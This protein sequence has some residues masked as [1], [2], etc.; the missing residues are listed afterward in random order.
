MI[1]THAH[2]GAQ[3]MTS[4]K[5]HRNL[6]ETENE[7]PAVIARARLRAGGDRMTDGK[8]TPCLVSPVQAN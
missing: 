6:P 1:A 2:R 8:V 3:T 4:G 7:K 5:N